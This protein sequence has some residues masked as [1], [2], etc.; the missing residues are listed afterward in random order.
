MLAPDLSKKLAPFAAIVNPRAL[1][2]NY[3]AIRIS[4]KFINACAAFGALEVAIETGLD[5]EIFVDGDS[6]LQVLK[7]LPPSEFEMHISNEQTLSWKCGAA[8]GQLALLN[9]KVEVVRPEW[10]E[11][12]EFVPIGSNFGK[13]LDLASLS[14]GSTALLSVGLYGIL[15]DNEG[16]LTG[17]SSDNNTMAS[18]RLGSK[19][20]SAPAACCLA[21]DG[22]KLVS[23]LANQEKSMIAIDGKNSVFVETP[24][25]KLVVKQI[26]PLKFDIKKVVLGFQSQ[27][28]KIDLNRDVITKFI[29]RA[30]ALAEDRGQTSVAISV[31]NGSV[32]LTFAEGKSSSEEYYLAEGQTEVNVVPITVDS[33]RL[34][35]AL[36]QASVIV[37]DYAAK[38]VLA[39]RGAEDFIFIL[40]GKSDKKDA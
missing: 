24:D 39:L 26:P 7:S 4:P 29:R 22:A 30:E 14:C 28:I 20:E 37:F 9:E 34:S 6:F 35:K 12:T 31:D 5:K 10:L 8:R 36:S 40:S 33:R 32:R 17:Y 3:R 18:A 27:E 21:P 11:K 23:M 1:S 16:S 19:I 25:T 13:S 2:I 38:D 15:L